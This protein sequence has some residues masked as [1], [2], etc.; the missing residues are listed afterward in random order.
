MDNKVDQEHQIAVYVDLDN[1]AIGVK[2]AKIAKLDIS[3]ILDRLVEKGKITVKKAYAD[4]TTWSQ[5]KRPFHECAIELIDIP[6]RKM[7]GKNSADIKMVVDAMELSYTKSHVDT[8]VLISGDSDFSPLVSQLR[9]NNK[10]II[11]LGVKHSSSNLLIDNCDEFI[12]YEDLVRTKKKRIRKTS[13][14]VT[15]KLTK[16]QEAAISLLLSSIAAL[17]R[18]NYEVIWG[19]MVKQTMKRKQPTFSE[20]YHGYTHFSRLLED[21]EK[22]QFIKVHKDQ[23]SGTYIID[24]LLEDAI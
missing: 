5:Y 22:N 1:I 13:K 21:A 24:E 23:R 17:Q 11:G 9:E 4:W 7:S 16:D 2:E 15:R 8:F 19:S 14:K 12:F 3:K 20:E 10:K 18:E 6:S